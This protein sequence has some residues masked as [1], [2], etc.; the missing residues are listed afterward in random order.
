MIIELRPHHLLDI[1]RDY[2]DGIVYQPH[3][4]GHAL[5]LVA[6]EVLERL[7]QEIIFV[8]AADSICRPCRRLRRDGSCADVLSQLAEPVSKQS[9]NDALDRRLWDYLELDRGNRLTVRQ[10]LKQVSRRLAGLERLC[11]HPGE[12]E[13]ARRAGMQKGLARLG[14]SG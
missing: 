12:D 9:Y 10:F 7:D 14:I 4:D 3:E 13:A 11:A 5:H 2:G 1:I 6:G 8:I